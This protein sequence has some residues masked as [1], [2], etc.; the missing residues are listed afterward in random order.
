MTTESSISGPYKPTIYL[1]FE[2]R[3]SGVRG[4]DQRHH[5]A[6]GRAVLMHDLMALADLIEAERLREAW[7]D[8]PLDNQ[9]IERVGLLVI[10]EM[11]SLKPLLPHPEV[12][13]IRDRVVAGGA[14]ANDHHPAGVADEDRR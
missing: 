8:L 12:A 9:L 11:R 4:A 2:I 1:N 3:H 14:C 6:L 5:L 13:Q 7:I 10:G